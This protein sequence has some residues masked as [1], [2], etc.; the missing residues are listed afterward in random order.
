MADSQSSQNSQTKA[1]KAAKA[2]RKANV[3]ESLKDIGSGTTNSLKNDLLKETGKDFLKQLLGQRANQQKNYSGEFRNGESLEMDRVLSGEREKQEKLQKQLSFERRLR[4][5]EQALTTRRGQELRMQLQA[6]VQELKAVAQVTPKL[7][8]EIEIAVEQA[9]NN[10]GVYHIFF[11]ERILLFVKDYKK[12]IESAS[13][14][15]HSANS[16]AQKKSFWG[17]YKSKHGG[18]SRLLSAED[19]L[20]RSAG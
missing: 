11:F 3:L 19:F 17:Q 9:P 4:E 12:N 5:E 6:L 2:A 18:A 8:E 15:L 20:Q 16:R 10:P 1:Q 14:W 13:T 7:A